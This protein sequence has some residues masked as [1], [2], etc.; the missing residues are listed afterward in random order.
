[1]IAQSA[2]I[3]LLGGGGAQDAGKFRFSRELKSFNPTYIMTGTWYSGQRNFVYHEG[4]WSERERERDAFSQAGLTAE[5]R[6]L[7]AVMEIVVLTRTGR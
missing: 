2:K 1:M 3:K 4:T 6:G 5:R 7:G